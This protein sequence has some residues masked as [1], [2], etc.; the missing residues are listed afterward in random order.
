ML[1]DSPMIT[2]MNEEGF[3]EFFFVASLA[4]G[5]SFGGD[6]SGLSI[7]YAIYDSFGIYFLY[8]LIIVFSFC[9][10]VLNNTLNL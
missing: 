9:R 3:R 2:W 6:L 10:E 1:S 4:L 7:Y 5:L 8:A